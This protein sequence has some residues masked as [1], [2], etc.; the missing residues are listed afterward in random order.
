MAHC[1]RLTALNLSH[2][3]NV[4]DEG[5]LVVSHGLDVLQTL[6]IDGIQW[7]TDQTLDDIR[8]SP[9]CR[10]YL[11]RQIW[12]DGFELSTD[13]L[14]RLIPFLPNLQTLSVSFSDN[15]SDS[16]L[17]DI[18]HLPNLLRLSLRKGR[19][20]TSPGFISA[21]SSPFLIGLQHLD[22]SD[23]PAIDDNAIREI[24]KCCGSQLHTLLLNWCWGISDVGLDNIITTCHQL[25]YFSL[26]GNHV[27]LGECLAW[28]PNT[29][30]QMRIL[31]LTQCNQVTD[32]VIAALAEQMPNLYIF[33]YFGERVGGSGGPEDI[34][35]YDLQKTINKV[36]ICQH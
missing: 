8:S 16:T 29:Q 33:D 20:F 10:D 35:Q 11:I 27:V 22:L 4:N 36:T 32:D 31:N 9:A 1:S 18:S 19:I 7:V 13:G 30:R 25:F 34:C 15:L 14:S 5:L 12:L 6:N 3:V 17:L 26:V 23:C 21:F 28:I 2:C 24:C